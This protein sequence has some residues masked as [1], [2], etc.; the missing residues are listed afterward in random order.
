MCLLLLLAVNLVYVIGEPL[1]GGLVMLP[2]EAFVEP[3][4]EGGRDV[5]RFWGFWYVC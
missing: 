5:W 2:D 3:V 1:I 4:G